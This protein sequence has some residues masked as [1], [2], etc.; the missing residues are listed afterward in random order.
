[1]TV[2]LVTMLPVAV[3]VTCAGDCNPCN[4][5]VGRCGADTLYCLIVS[6]NFNGHLEAS[7]VKVMNRFSIL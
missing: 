3:V 5:H 6:G 7:L 4:C 2:V 1:M